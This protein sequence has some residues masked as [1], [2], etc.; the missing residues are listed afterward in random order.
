MKR[1]IELNENYVK[2]AIIFHMLKKADKNMRRMRKQTYRL[3]VKPNGTLEMK[4][5]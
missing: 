2:M 3:I 5:T 4:I 1:I